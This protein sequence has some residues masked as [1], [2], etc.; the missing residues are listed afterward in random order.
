MFCKN[1]SII[2]ILTGLFF[3][4][5]N[6]YPLVQC[7]AY[8]T[9]Q[10]NVDI[11]LDFWAQDCDII[12][13]IILTALIKHKIELKM[14]CQIASKPSELLKWSFA[15][16]KKKSH[17]MAF[18]LLIFISTKIIILFTKHGFFLIWSHDF[19]KMEQKKENY[20]LKYIMKDI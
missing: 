5:T 18:Y 1:I 3:E 15:K 2:S 14:N 8:I 13:T 16:G 9:T 10:F 20:V 11:N 4:N 12:I 6:F 19:R 7:L 17:G